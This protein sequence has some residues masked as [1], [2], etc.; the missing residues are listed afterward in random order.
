MDGEREDVMTR[1][2]SGLAEDLA[3]Q[4]ELA[5]HRSQRKLER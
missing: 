4:C 2:A 3:M 1:Y 5:V